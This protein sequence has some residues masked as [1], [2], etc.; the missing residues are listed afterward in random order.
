MNG[1]PT[2]PSGIDAVVHKERGNAFKDRPADQRRPFGDARFLGGAVL[3][4]SA[5]RGSW[6]PAVGETLLT[7]VGKL[8]RA[9]GHPQAIP[10]EYLSA[11]VTSFWEHRAE[12]DIFDEK[13]WVAWRYGNNLERESL[14]YG[15]VVLDALRQRQLLVP[16]DVLD[17][18][19]T[20]GQDDALLADALNNSA[21]T[22]DE[23]RKW[24]ARLLAGAFDDHRLSTAT[25]L[26]RSLIAAV[27][28]LTIAAETRLAA[29]LS[30]AT[31]KLHLSLSPAAAAQVVTHDI[32]GRDGM[33]ERFRA[34]VAV[35]AEMFSLPE[36]D[37]SSTVIA[38]APRGWR[39]ETHAA[40]PAIVTA[41]TAARKWQLP[42]RLDSEQ[43]LPSTVCLLAGKP[44][45]KRLSFCYRSSCE[46]RA[47]LRMAFVRD[48]LHERFE[49]SLA[50][51]LAR[52]FT[53]HEQWPDIPFVYEWRPGIWPHRP[54]QPGPLAAHQALLD[55]MFPNE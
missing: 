17:V 7:G 34:T 10:S 45:Q 14:R 13:S 20:R 40:T 33:V 21:L 29:A 44:A 42:L 39:T 27:G 28:S 1:L 24:R 43:E 26:L 46:S 6:D 37:M 25:T 41:A 11:L 51:E 3:K 53:Q 12:T 9:H 38:L 32:R 35:G 36:R 55:L 5:G 8:H 16:D 4:P 50:I 19:L 47:V 15:P 54:L 18:R 30:N 52:V 48:D 2:V 49:R 22:R 31:V 23:A